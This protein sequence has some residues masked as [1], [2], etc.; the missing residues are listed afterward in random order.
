[1]DGEGFGSIDFWVMAT[2]MISSFV[3]GFQQERRFGYGHS[4][5]DHYS[6]SIVACF[7]N[8]DPDWRHEQEDR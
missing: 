5:V 3:Q 8:A 6:V 7:G 4:Y 1:V 2:K